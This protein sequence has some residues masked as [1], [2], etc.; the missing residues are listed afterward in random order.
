MDNK[1]QRIVSVMTNLVSGN[2]S[3]RKK[4]AKSL[5]KEVLLESN[6]GLNDSSKQSSNIQSNSSTGLNT[7]NSNSHSS[8]TKCNESSCLSAIVSIF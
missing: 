3:T 7:L 6:I 5:E 2:H 4:H 1:S 8:Q